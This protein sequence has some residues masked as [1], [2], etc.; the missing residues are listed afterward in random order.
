MDELFFKD[1]KSLGHVAL[2]TVISFIALFLFIRVSGKRTLAKLNAF[3]FVV[4]VALGSTLAYMMLAMVPVAE[5][6]LVLALIIIMQYAFAWAAKSSKKME[7]LIN[8]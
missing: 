1:W 2:C 7:V 5:G 8:S 4:S 6:G 3:D